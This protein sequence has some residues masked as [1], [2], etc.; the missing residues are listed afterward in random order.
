[1]APGSMNWYS[2][3]ADFAALFSG[4]VTSLQLFDP[5]VPAELQQFLV[6]GSRGDRLFVTHMANQSTYAAI[7]A[8]LNQPPFTLADGGTVAL[9]G[10]FVPIPADRALKFTWQVP[11]F[12]ATL[13]STNPT[14]T[15][16]SPDFSL[17]AA[18]G[19]LVEAGATDL[20]HDLPLAIQYGDPFPAA[21]PRQATIDLFSTVKVNNGNRQY[22]A[23]VLMVRPIEAL[24]GA[25]AP[26]LSGPRNVRVG[27]Q[28]GLVIANVGTTPVVA[29]DPPAIG[30]AT[31]YNID[32]VPL[33]QDLLQQ[34]VLRTQK[35]SL[36]L[37]SGVL[38]AGHTYALA[39]YAVVGRDFAHPERTRA[40]DAT[41]TLDAVTP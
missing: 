3:G 7:D 39:V 22:S 20:Q 11:Q 6:D 1:M 12:Q 36:E 41:S 26:V 40:T 8:V 14:A 25:I 28:S 33:D 4:G 24:K 16:P 35:T 13:L 9:A 30:T 10:N 17:L 2:L 37:P 32:V 31:S 23:E 18:G 19:I 15:N 5:M 34:V 38:V 27:G 29:W 21:W